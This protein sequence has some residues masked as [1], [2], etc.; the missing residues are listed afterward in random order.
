MQL[1]NRSKREETMLPYMAQTCPQLP[2][3]A[4]TCPHNILSKPL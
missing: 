4:Q 3:M 2:Y 1:F